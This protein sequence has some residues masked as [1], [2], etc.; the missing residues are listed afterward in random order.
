MSPA[1]EAPATD[2]EA[3]LAAA[4]DAALDPVP[5]GRLAPVVDRLIRDYRSGSV[6]TAPI[7]RTGDDA[8]AYA[9]Y[10]M[11]ATHAAVLDVFRRAAG[12]V[13]DPAGL[14]DLGGGT[15]AAVWAA[16]QTWPSLRR[17]T[18]LEA[19]APARALGAKLAAGAG[20]PA[21]RDARWE[22]AVL[23]TGTELA[24]A[25]LVTACYLLGELPGPVRD[26]LVDAA[27]R[28]APVV[29]VV[30]PGTPAGYAR[31]LAARARLVAA[32]MTVVAPC[33]HS[34]GCP[35]TG[36]DWCHF[37]VRVSRSSRHR[38]LKAGSLGHE[39][40][41]FSY[42]VATRS[43]TD[44]AA[45]GR[46]IRHPQSR[47]GLV[48]LRVCSTDGSLRDTPVPRSRKE[49]FRAARDTAWGDPWPPA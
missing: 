26:A 33:P 41:K 45:S 1:P 16:A 38:A 20:A 11:P 28:A 49:L 14:L 21:V 34:G 40:E 39:D 47:K 12:R 46:V 10:R 9:A 7:L 4:L 42:V 25:D 32:G 27:A 18:V 13:P 24:P 15:G 17:A 6:P 31:V 19:A 8:A 36:D 35:V 3:D 23:G 30:E 29:A 5:A 37:A 43:D 22:P 48:T 44:G 2:L